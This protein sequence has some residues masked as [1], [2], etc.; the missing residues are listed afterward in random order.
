MSEHNQPHL[1]RGMG[2]LSATA[3]NMLEMIGIGPFI[4]I[5][6]I[7]A[8]MGGPQAMLGWLLGA[9]I[10]IC[11][12]LVWAGARAAMPGSGG[13]YRYLQQ[14]FGPARLGRLMSFLFIWQT[15]CTA[16]FSIASGAVGFSNYTKYLW[17]A[18][19]ETQGEILAVGLCVAVTV[20]LRLYRNIRSIGRLSVVMW[21]VVLLTVGWVLIAGLANFQLNRVLDF[22]PN[23]FNL[24]WSFFVGLGGATL[25]AVYDYG[26]YN[27]VC[28]F[29]GEVKDPGRII[30]RTVLLSILAV[31]A[32]YL[33]MTITIMGVVPWREAINPDSLAYKAIV[34]DFIQRLYGSQPPRS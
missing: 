32:I 34:A 10:A 23:A 26:G 25:T 21:V 24:S 14:A 4:T 29:G 2:L 6:L 7:I 33:T 8:A 18:M 30:P 9:V 31:A 12:G 16:P 13:S 22:P 27:N 19:T 5:P 15:I 17:L 20:L 11:D 3:A 1:I 28:F